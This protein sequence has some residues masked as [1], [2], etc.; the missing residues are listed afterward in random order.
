MGLAPSAAA[1]IV[2]RGPIDG[3]N[4]I[5]IYDVFLHNIICGSAVLWGKSQRRVGLQYGKETKS[6]T[7]E[8]II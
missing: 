1:V 3:H 7:F 6:P 5:V 2:I 8:H 4:V